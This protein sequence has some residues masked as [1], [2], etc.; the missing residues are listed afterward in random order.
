[1]DK[2]TYTAK[3]SLCIRSDDSDGKLRGEPMYE[4]RYIKSADLPIPP[5]PGISILTWKPTKIIEVI[6]DNNC[7]VTC[8]FEDQILPAE[9]FEMLME[10]Y[11]NYLSRG[12]WEED[13]Q[14]RTWP[15]DKTTGQ[16][17][18]KKTPLEKRINRLWENPRNI[19]INSSFLYFISIC[20]HNGD[21]YRYVG[22]ARDKGRLNEYRNN[23]KKIR[24]GEEHGERQGYRAVHFAL[25]AALNNGWD[26]QCYPL[27]NCDDMNADQLEKCRITELDC[28]LNGARTWRVSQMSTLTL[29]ELL[30]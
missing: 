6:I 10:K 17:E 21:E 30:R 3:F 20:D 24:A 18:W 23:M 2:R 1:M 5:A 8:H 29:K 9:R 25:Y 26:I 13:I 27:E 22:K 28:K 4:L 15:E 7:E 16:E 11:K 12:G 19:D 14:F